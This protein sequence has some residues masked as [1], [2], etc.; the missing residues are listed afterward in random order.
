M[1]NLNTAVV[2]R[3]A[4]FATALSLSAL[5]GCSKPAAPVGPGPAPYTPPPMAAYDLPKKEAP[6]AEAPKKNTTGV[7]LDATIAKAC[8]IA[9]PKSYFEFDSAKL[10]HT[11]QETTEFANVADCFRTGPLK[12]KSLEVVGRA[13]P[14]GSEEYNQE[15]GKSRADSVSDALQE[16]GLA[17]DKITTRSTGEDMAKGVDESGWAKDRRVDI[18]LKK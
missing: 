14:R 9:Q 8:G 3:T 13:D 11:P 18:M 15:L 4:L 10:E 7:F 6:V 5:V 2:A 12:G 17:K 16:R 1:L